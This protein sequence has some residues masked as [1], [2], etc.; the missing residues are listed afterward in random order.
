MKPPSKAEALR[1]E[2]T[3]NP[4]PEAVKDPLFHGGEFFDP[5]DVV[6]VK[7]EMLRRARVDGQPV[8]RTSA[9][10]GFSRPTF[11]EAQTAFERSGVAGLVPRKRGPRGPHKLGSE[12]M[13]F[14]RA[15]VVPSEPIRAAELARKIEEKFGLVVHPRTIER[16]VRRRE[17]KLS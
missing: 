17:K 2:G 14:L 3:L 1:E 7:Y 10:F 6:Q 11:Y 16:A 12:V 15:E 5:K 8:S 4:R 9:D 13:T